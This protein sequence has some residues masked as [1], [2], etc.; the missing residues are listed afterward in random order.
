MP[1]KTIARIGRLVLLYALVAAVAAILTVRLYQ[2]QIEQGESYRLFGRP[3]PPAPGRG[4]R[5]A[6]WC[7]QAAAR[8]WPAITPALRWPSSRQRPAEGLPDTA[9]E[10]AMLDRL[11]SLLPPATPDVDSTAYPLPARYTFRWSKASV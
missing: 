7:M 1:A 6:V 3:Q 11:V 5:H 4:A 10:T 2:L 9:Q 8:S